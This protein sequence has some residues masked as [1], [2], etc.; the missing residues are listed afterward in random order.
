[1]L[2]FHTFWLFLQIEADPDPAYRL[3][4]DPVPDPAYHF[5]AY[6]DPT[7]FHADPDPQ[8]CLVSSNF[9]KK[10]LLTEKGVVRQKRTT[11]KNK[12]EMLEELD[13]LSV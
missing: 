11:N 2:I 8:H 13:V 10:K 7:F 3:A 5:D 4:A 1:M 6:P 9:S 12:L